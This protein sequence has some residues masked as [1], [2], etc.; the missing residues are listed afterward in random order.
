MGFRCLCW[1]A[2]VGLFYSDIGWLASVRLVLLV[3]V[4]RWWFCVLGVAGL[5][6]F[7]GGFDS[8]MVACG[9]GLLL[10]LI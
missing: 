6:L 3:I 1:L 7:S 8:W 4:L 2:V 5:R 9:G 10:V